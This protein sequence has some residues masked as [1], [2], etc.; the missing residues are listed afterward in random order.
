MQC[1]DAFRRDL[2][3]LGPELE[4]GMDGAVQHEV[5]RLGVERTDR[6][7]VADLFADHAISQLLPASNIS[8]SVICAVSGE[9]RGRRSGQPPSP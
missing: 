5:R 7:M 4:F 2:D 6:R 8:I 3:R 9:F 1:N